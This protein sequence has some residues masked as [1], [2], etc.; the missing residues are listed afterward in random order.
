MP[1]GAIGTL[2]LQ[3]GEPYLGYFQ[4]V[5][6][7]SDAA[8]GI[9]VAVDGRFTAAAPRIKVGLLIGSVYRLRVTNIPGS[10]GQEVFPT[11]E[12]IDR[13]H[14][15]PR[16]AEQYPIP[17]HLTQTDLRLALA[18]RYVTRVIYLEDPR[19]ALP[20]AQPAA[21]QEWFDAAPGR[22]PLEVADAMGRPVAILRIGGRSPENIADPGERFLFGSP[23]LR[24]L[25]P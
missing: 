22:D 3:R 10:E 4:P 12:L 21:S 25:G 24:R 13:T 15:P 17:V 19:N 20:V 16:L 23:P 9:A 14:P 18:G 1:P 2:R 11:L 8:V 6:F 7:F 5:E